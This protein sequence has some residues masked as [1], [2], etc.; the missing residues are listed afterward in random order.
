[1]LLFAIIMIL[2]MRFARGGLMQIIHALSPGVT[3]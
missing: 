3:H 1:M 2:T